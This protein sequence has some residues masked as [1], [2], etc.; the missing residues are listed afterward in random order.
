[1]EI[2]HAHRRAKTPH[3]PCARCMQ[4]V[5]ARSD[6][7]TQNAFGQS[8]EKSFGMILR[9][10]RHL[11][12]E[13]LQFEH[14][15]TASVH[16]CTNKE[17]CGL[18][19]AIRECLRQHGGL[20]GI[21]PVIERQPQ[22]APECMES[23]HGMVEQAGVGPQQSCEQSRMRKAGQDQWKRAV[24]PW[25]EPCRQRQDTTRKPEQP[26]PGRGRVYIFL[27]LSPQKTSVDFPLHYGAAA[28]TSSRMPQSFKDKDSLIQQLKE[29]LISSLNL[30]DISPEDIQP[31]QPLFGQGMGLDSID[32]LELVIS[33]EKTY[34]IKFSNSEQAKRSLSNLDTLADYII[35]NSP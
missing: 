27:V 30:P 31:Q 2:R 6:F 7:P 15:L 17:K 24:F 11:V 20:C 10:V 19:A 28:I 26:P 12:P 13:R 18:H 8:P 35:A 25:R 23:T 5:R 16:F 22:F 29:L 34:G 9:M 3:P 32:A 14:C 21:W 33:L 1:M 4:R